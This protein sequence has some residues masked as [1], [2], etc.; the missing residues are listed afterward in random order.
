MGWS[1]VRA[2]A[3]NGWWRASWQ[4]AILICCLLVVRRL[5]GDRLSPRWRAG[6]WMLIALRLVL[7]A[8]PPSP[9]SLFN[10]APRVV[11]MQVAPVPMTPIATR[12]HP[13]IPRQSS[14]LL[15]WP[16]WLAGAIVMTAGAIGSNLVFLRRVRRTAGQA[17]DEMIECWQSCARRVGVRRVPPVVCTDAVST[18]ALFGLWRG[19]LLMPADF[20]RQVTQEE[21]RLIL[22]HEMTH[23]RRRDLPVGWVMT[24]L[25]IVH[26]FNPLVWIA[27]ACWRADIEE[28]CDQAVVQSVD[29]AARTD[30]GLV[31]LKLA[32][33]AM[34]GAPSP[35]LGI[36]DSKREL[37]HR[38]GALVRDRRAW[39]LCAAVLF[40]LLALFGLTDARASAAGPATQ[41]GR[42][43]SIKA[44]FYSID[45][46]RLTDAGL[47]AG[48]NITLATPDQVAKFTRAAAAD[49]FVSS[50]TILALD[51][52][53]A[54]I[55]FISNYPYLADYKPTTKPDG[56]VDLTP[57]IGNVVTGLEWSVRPTLGGG[58]DI[59]LDMHV[60]LT[61]VVG[62]DVVSSPRDNTLKVQSPRV[63]TRTI[64]TKVAVPDGHTCVIIGEDTDKKVN[65]MILTPTIV[66]AASVTPKGVTPAASRG[67]S[68]R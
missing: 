47:D 60:K 30:Y 44:T 12:D 57:Q 31:L 58:A 22:L 38:I 45:S 33:G 62:I 28:A 10:L 3:L 56:H 61:K 51:G 15:V 40:L 23:V 36:V 4:S 54:D 21:A 25:R 27:C 37:R 65:V 20:S 26:W 43:V 14:G 7:P 49:G 2:A 42:A 66:A 1:E 16:I 46:A 8:L 11:T 34:T 52:Q 24:G 13:A 48:R 5:L 19:R 50:P 55:R 64:E 9:W 18:P 67:S 35:A 29:A 63:D 53:T 32:T 41:P 39:P 17:S 6:L 68:G 59:A